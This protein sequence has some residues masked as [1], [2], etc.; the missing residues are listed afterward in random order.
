MS[1][2][3]NIMVTGPNGLRGFID[4]VAPP[5]NTGEPQAL[6]QFETGQ[7]VY[8]PMKLL[9]KQPDG[10]YQLMYDPNSHSNLDNSGVE[11]ALVLPVIA[12]ELK[13][14]KRPVLTGGVRIKKMVQEHQEEVDEPLLREDVQVERTPINRVL[15][16]PVQAHYEG[17][18]LV[19]PVLEEVLVV[20]KRL[21]LKEELRVTK[22][23]LVEHQ[24]QQVPLRREEVVVEPITPG[25]TTNGAQGEASQA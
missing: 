24:P 10:S 23:Q 12:E 19:I 25:L 18:T 7:R 2:S 13:V 20:E 16:N 22:R 15:E 8:V 11:G 6:V 5:D 9:A 21:M 17:E 4:Q 14:Q 1:E 3:Q